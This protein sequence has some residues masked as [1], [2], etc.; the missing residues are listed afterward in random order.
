MASE[1]VLQVVNMCLC[2]FKS[3]SKIFNRLVNGN[4]LA[5]FGRIIGSFL[6]L[7]VNN[8]LL[9]EN[10]LFV[11]IFV[12]S[13]S[14][15]GLFFCCIQTKCKLLNVSQCSLELFRQRSYS[16]SVIL[17]CLF[18]AIDDNYILLFLFNELADKGFSI[19]KFLLK[20]DSFFI[21]GLTFIRYYGSCCF[22]LTKLVRQNLNGLLQLGAFSDFAIESLF[23]LLDTIF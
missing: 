9:K 10:N 2:S 16:Q 23:T 17:P 22:L 11:D 7:N 15:E 12:L 6:V 19:P 20:E 14:I 21:V 5:C 4:S 18:M 3:F 1:L 13:C 8:L